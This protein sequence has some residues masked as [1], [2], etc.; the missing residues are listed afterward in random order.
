MKE[1]KSVLSLLIAVF[2]VIIVIGI[3]ISSTNLFN[4][5]D[6]HS[7][8]GN[9]N[10]AGYPPISEN[11]PF[12]LVWTLETPDGTYYI[13]DEEG[14]TPL[15]SIEE[16]GVFQVGDVVKIQGELSTLSKLDGSNIN[17]ILTQCIEEITPTQTQGDGCPCQNN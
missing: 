17:V 10:Q 4:S 3:A 13:C 14:T 5:D 7:F 8:A 16:Y 9:L 11:I 1:E 2:A 6:E 15:C 12:C